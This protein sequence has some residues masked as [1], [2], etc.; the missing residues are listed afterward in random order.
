MSRG[1]KTGGRTKKNSES[2]RIS[3]VPSQQALNIYAEWG[4][5][6][7]NLDKA[8]IHFQDS[9]IT[10]KK[11]SFFEKLEKD[12][13]GKVTNCHGNIMLILENDPLIA[14]KIGYDDYKNNLTVRGALPWDTSGIT[15]IW[16]E[17]DWS[18]LRMYLASDPYNLQRSYKLTDSVAYLQGGWS[19]HPIKDYLESCLWDGVPRIESLFIDYL[20]AE[21]THYVRQ[22]TR[23]TLIACV[24]RIYSPGIKFDYTPVLY[25]PSGIGKST[26]IRK[27]GKDWFSDG[28]NFGMIRSRRALK[29]MQGSWVMEVQ[30]LE[31][32]MSSAHKSG[33][34]SF[35]SRTEDTYRPFYKTHTVDAPRQCVFFVTTNA[36]PEVYNRRF[37]KVPVWGKSALSAVNMSDTDVSQIWGEAMHHYQSGNEELFLPAELEQLTLQS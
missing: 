31:E 28:F 20:G 5:K 9:V 23:K 13:R 35:I 30:G 15:R 7:S 26:L 24:A 11:D 3:F 32:Y 33:I 18:E 25:G 36:V 21:D 6:T 27:L 1:K 8:I 29:D 10:P 2:R 16:T 14:G 4:S 34:E 22:V 17:D 37:W 19:Y 12:R